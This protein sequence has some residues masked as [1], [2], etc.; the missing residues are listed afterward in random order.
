MVNYLLIFII[1][2]VIETIVAYG[3]GYRKKKHVLAII[4][5]NAITHP[6]LTL[7][8][9]ILVIKNIYTQYIIFLL[10]V[11]VVLSEWKLLELIFK[12]KHRKYFLLAFAMN[13]FSYVLGIILHT[14]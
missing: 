5:I 2:I 1:N 11:L 4:S 10:E 12:N 7:I 9:Y 8:I 6:I 14:F 3:L 13:I